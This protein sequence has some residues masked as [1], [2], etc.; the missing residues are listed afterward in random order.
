MLV[1]ILIPL[2]NKERYIQETLNSVI[3]QTFPLWELI[4][5]DDGSTDSS[6]EIA[7]NFQSSL[8]KQIASRINILTQENNGQSHARYTALLN[9]KGDFVALL[10]GDDLWSPKKLEIQVKYLQD[11]PKVDL[12]LSNYC[13]FPE[14]SGRPRAVSFLPVQ[15]KIT[16]WANT[17]Y[18]GGLVESTGLFRTEFLRKY[19]SAD[20]PAMSGGLEL[21]LYGLQSNKVACTEEYLCA[22]R[23][24]SEGWHLRKDDLI[25]S[26]QALSIKR[27]L[28]EK[29]RNEMM[30]GLRRHLFFWSFRQEPKSA[31]LRLF[32][33]L[34]VSEGTKSLVYAIKVI[35]RTL[36]A[37]IRY[38][39]LRSKVEDLRKLFRQ[40]FE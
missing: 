17:E 19:M 4:L 13:I 40:D 9:A 25:N 36:I 27:D 11:H 1:S 26:Y 30:L 16:G 24:I 8:P 6:L 28:S 22:Y 33:S 21:C 14:G 38:F 18:F 37:Q 23:E 31:R 29:I 10:D 39:A 15:K 3:N 32:L 35:L 7:L 34:G 5:V 12:L 20:A 2:Y